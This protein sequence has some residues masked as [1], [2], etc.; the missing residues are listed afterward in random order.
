M[1]NILLMSKTWQKINLGILTAILLIGIGIFNYQPIQ[2]QTEENLP[3]QFI[4]WCQRQ[5]EFS[6]DIQQVVQVLLREV[7]T[8]DCSQAAMRLTVIR[9]VNV[10]SQNISDI[11]PLASLTNLRNLQLYN[12]QISDIRP[13]KNLT[14]LTNLQLGYNP[15]A[16][17]TPLSE[18]V[19]LKSLSLIRTK[20]TDIS[21]LKG[22]TELRELRLAENQISNIQPLA[23][24]TN[25]NRLD[26][27]HNEISDITPVQNLT[28]LLELDISFNNIREAKTV[29]QSLSNLKEVNLIGNPLPD[30]V[31]PLDPNILCIE[32]G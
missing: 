18:L 20:L 28:D 13:L 11:S 17:I 1:K 7:Q 15:I 12:N 26:L 9:N 5:N 29:L 3:T 23:G 27:S 32:L 4:E 31:C 24:L 25:L 22:L 6:T 14:E 21:A 2:A 19:N 30:N 16:D 8:K 10:T